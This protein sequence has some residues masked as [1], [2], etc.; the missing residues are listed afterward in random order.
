MRNE[1]GNLVA[2]LV[3]YALFAMIGDEIA[4]FLPMTIFLFHFTFPSTPPQ[5]P[6]APMVPSIYTLQ[7][8]DE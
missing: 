3:R 4:S 6:F 8:L 7:A 2:M 5:P 1:R